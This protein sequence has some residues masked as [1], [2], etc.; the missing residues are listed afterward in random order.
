MVSHQ[1]DMIRARVEFAIRQGELEV[2]PEHGFY[3]FHN[4]ELAAEIDAM[5]CSVLSILNPI[6]NQVGIVALRGPMAT[7]W[8]G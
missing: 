1:F 6:L 7:S 2:R 8:P 4:R 5:R 3:V